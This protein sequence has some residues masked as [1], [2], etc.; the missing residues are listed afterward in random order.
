MISVFSR[1]DQGQ[2]HITQDLKCWSKSMWKRKGYSRIVVTM[3]PDGR[4]IAVSAENQR[5]RVFELNVSGMFWQVQKLDQKAKMMASSPDGEYLVS[6]TEHIDGK[7]QVWKG[8]NT[9]SLPMSCVDEK[10][11]NHFGGGIASAMAFSSDGRL[12]LV[13]SDKV[14]VCALDRLTETLTKIQVLPSD[15]NSIETLAWTSDGRTL[16]A[17]GDRKG[18]VE[19]WTT[20]QD[21]QM[22]QTAK[23]DQP[24]DYCRRLCFSPDG[25]LLAAAYEFQGWCM[26]KKDELSEDGWTMALNRLDDGWD[27]KAMAFHPDGRSIVRMYMKS[28]SVW[29]IERR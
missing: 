22:R 27:P 20:D 13:L 8:F 17:S 24:I 18:H 28:L 25:N 6:V 26:W 21:G 15:S 29:G 23:L 5:I 16:A 3:R 14:I 12:G 11:V 7:V 10:H 1:D 19:I 9:P 4:A 2:Y